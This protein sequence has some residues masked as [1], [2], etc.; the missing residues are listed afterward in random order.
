[1][2]IL[3]GMIYCECGGIY[4]NRTTNI[5][6][7]LK[8]NIH[9]DFLEFGLPCKRR[10]PKSKKKSVDLSKVDLSKITENKI[11][12]YDIEWKKDTEQS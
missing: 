7:H 3:C 6:T 11:L 10:S 8:S 4:R 9:K 2:V 1:M 12:E 5:N